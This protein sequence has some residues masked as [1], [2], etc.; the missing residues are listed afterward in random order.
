MIQSI[1]IAIWLRTVIVATLGGGLL[2]PAASVASVTAASPD[3]GF[4]AASPESQG[5]PPAALSELAATVQSFVERDSLVGGELLVI[6]NRRVVLHRAFGMADRDAK[7]AWELN[8][9]C[10]L[11]SMTKTF[12]GAAAQLLIDRGE[13]ALN[14]RVSKYLPSF[15]NDKSREITVEQLMTH[16]SGL[17]LSIMTTREDMTKF[18]SLADQT[19]A[20]GERG[21]EFAPGSK[22]WYSDAGSDTLAAVVEKIAGRTIDEFW[23]AELFEPLGM[24]DTFVP[25]NAKDP[26]FARIA[27]LYAGQAG[28]WQRSWAPADG[29]FY[30][31]AWGSQTAYGTAIDYAKFLAMW[32]DGGKAGD[33]RVLS[34]EAVNRTLAPTSPMCM[35][36]SE[37]RFPTDFAGLEVWYG[38]MAVL[39]VPKDNP[40]SSTPQIIGHSGSDGTIAWAWPDRDLMILLFTQ[41]RG[42]TALLRVEEAIERLLLHP[43]AAV[44]AAEIPE[45]FKPMVGTYIANFAAFRNEEFEVLVKNGKLALDIPSQMVFELIE[46]ETVAAGSP[47]KFALAPDQI[48]VSFDKEENGQYVL[49]KVHQA[50]MTFD[51]PRKGTKQAREASTLAKVD[52][53]KVKPLLGA[54]FHPEAKANMA[55]LLEDGVLTLKSPQ[56]VLFH[57]VPSVDGKTWTLKEAPG[58]TLSF[59]FNEKG[60]V[61]SMTRHSGDESLVMPRRS[62]T[63]QEE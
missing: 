27:P 37:V 12:T 19:R 2:G 6:K 25:L 50:G 35:I 52:P 17:P 53:E 58:L 7:L 44:A 31:Y 28:A 47:W 32:I 23:R 38:R 11:R 62:N 40:A 41:T 10:N 14:D 36:G 33:R 42:S 56:G 48:S 59:E 60:E 3:G 5:L 46:P 61:V 4:L 49:L 63:P 8:S 20:V 24:R 16:R 34:V 1:A 26:R 45:M 13:L 57:F 29:P 54:Y 22:F 15:D 39:H 30:P 18:A 43:E 9:I 51:L 21:P 55:V